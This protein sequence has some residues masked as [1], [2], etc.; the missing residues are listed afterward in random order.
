MFLNQ[1]I[2]I[3]ELHITHDAINV[4]INDEDYNSW[5]IQMYFS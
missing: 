5:K 1:E 4:S 3:I 2:S